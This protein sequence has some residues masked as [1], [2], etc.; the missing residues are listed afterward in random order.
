MGRVTI[1]ECSRS[2]CSKGRKQIPTKLRR[3]CGNVW[4][5]I[6]AC[7]LRM[8]QESGRMLDVMS[9]RLPHLMFSIFLGMLK[10]RPPQVSHV[11]KSNKIINEPIDWSIS[12]TNLWWMMIHYDTMS[13]HIYQC[14]YPSEPIEAVVARCIFFIYL[15]YLPTPG[16][17]CLSRSVYLWLSI[18]LSIDQTIAGINKKTSTLNKR[19]SMLRC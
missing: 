12:R 19:A 13:R 15:L 16:S 4:L 14:V 18:Y 7:M 5:S 11:S 8:C 6:P 3:S 1:Y 9:S 10:L 2:L 17:I